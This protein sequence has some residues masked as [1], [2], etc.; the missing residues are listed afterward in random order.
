LKFI[1][2]YGVVIALVVLFVAFSIYSPGLFLTRGNLSTIIT[3][4]SSIFFVAFGVTIPLRAGEFDLSIGANMVFAAVATGMLF[5]N[6]HWPVGMLIIASLV[7]GGVIGVVNALLVV[8]LRI[9][10]FIATLGTSSVIVGIGYGVSHSAVIGPVQGSLVGFASDSWGGFPLAVYYGWAMAIVLW[11]VF[12]HT[13]IGR[14][15]LFAGGNPH[16]AR[17][18]GVKTRTIKSLAY[19]F[20]GMIC[21]F[22][23]LLLVGSV[24]SADPSSSGAYLLGPYAAAFVGT[25]VLQEGR[26]NV[27]GTVVGTYLISLA[28]IGLELFGA[29]HWFGEVF[30]GLIL[31]IALGVARFGLKGSDSKGR[32]RGLSTGEFF[33]ANKNS[34]DDQMRAEQP[35]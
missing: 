29:P 34:K 15:W 7:I 16:A 35:T 24:G 20:G 28:E 26:F 4:Q 17:L 23:G 32:W 3:S 33:S 6:D 13:A 31:I 8:G 19:I 14:Y 2:R 10:G 11:L 12:E 27:I 9:N 22:A 18:A 21:G 5:Q 1:Q 25:A 30:S